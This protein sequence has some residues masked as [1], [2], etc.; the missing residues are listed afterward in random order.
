VIEGGN[1]L[2]DA[3]ADVRCGIV[4]GLEE[5]GEDRGLADVTEGDRGLLANTGFR[6]LKSREEL[7]QDGGV[8]DLT[9]CLGGFSANCGTGVSEVAAEGIED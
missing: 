9:K 4:D 2:D 7:G 1:G 3:G 6:V 5:L 8:T